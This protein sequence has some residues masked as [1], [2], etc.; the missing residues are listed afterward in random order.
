M[1]VLGEKYPLDHFIILAWQ[2]FWIRC[3]SEASAVLI[4]LK[5]HSDMSGTSVS[6]TKLNIHPKR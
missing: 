3:I 4:S 5:I 1:V 6:V 2:A